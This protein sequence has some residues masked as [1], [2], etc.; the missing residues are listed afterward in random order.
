MNEILFLGKPYARC[1]YEFLKS[2]VMYDI[3]NPIND[4]KSIYYWLLV[5]N[6]KDSNEEL[7][8]MAMQNLKELRMFRR[9]ILRKEQIYVGPTILNKHH[10]DGVLAW[11]KNVYVGPFQWGKKHGHANQIQRWE[12]DGSIFISTFVGE[13]NDDK[14]DTGT[15]I[16]KRNNI[17]ISIYTGTWQNNQRNKGNYK[18]SYNNNKWGTFDGTF[19]NNKFKHGKL[20][21]SE[22]TH[23][24]GD[25]RGKKR[26]GQG[27]F[28]NHGE[29]YEG[30]WR[31]DSRHGKGMQTYD[32][33]SQY[34]G[35]WKK[36]E[37]HGQG[38]E[39]RPLQVYSGEFWNGTY[40]GRG[41]MKYKDTESVYVGQWKHGVKCGMGT[42]TW[43]NGDYYTGRFKYG[44]S[45]G[46]GVFVAQET[47]MK[48]VQSSK[49]RFLVEAGSYEGEWER[50]PPPSKQWNK[51]G[52]FTCTYFDT[53]NKYV[54]TLRPGTLKYTRSGRGVMTYA[55]GTSYDGHWQNNKRCGVGTMTYADGTVY[56]G[57]WWNDLR[58]GH[59]KIR[60]TD[61]SIIYEGPWKNNLK[62]S[63]LKRTRDGSWKRA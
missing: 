18:F 14:I 42:Y 41:T 33:G 20:K 55:D 44:A 51:I 15:S 6:F 21:Y 43:S 50:A 1:V 13:F 8:L 47:E 34:D 2:N 24:I 40:H 27:I 60:R 49:T 16:I 26:H 4:P 36:N 23:Y 59:G 39:T 38:I 22:H 9:A 46:K 56:D 12:N 62:Q 19:E 10:G 7:F 54:G 30:E 3:V 63:R 57:D 25:F 32:N 53:G 5:C 58:H 61:G 35:F 37:Q 11:D 45:H 31:N 48:K 52:I 28:C 29:K 17:V